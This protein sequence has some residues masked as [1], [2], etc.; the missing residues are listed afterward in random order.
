MTSEV[1]RTHLN[2]LTDIPTSIEKILAHLGRASRTVAPR[3]TRT[4]K[5]SCFS[6]AACTTPSPREG[7]LKLK[8]FPYVQAEG[9]P[10]GEL[11][12]GPNAL[13]DENLPVIV[14]ATRDPAG[15]RL[16]PALPQDFADSRIREKE[17]RQSHRHCH[18]RRPR[19]HPR[20]PDRTIYVPAAPEL[21]LPILEVVPLQLFA[22]HF[23]ILNGH[24]VGQPA[25]P[26]QVG[27]RMSEPLQA[28]SGA[29]QPAKLRRVPR[30]L[31]PDHHRHRD[32]PAH[33]AHGHLRR[34]QQRRARPRRHHTAHRHGR[35]AFH[36]N[37][38][39][40]NGACLSLCRL[41]LHLC[42]PGTETRAS[43]TSPAG[44]S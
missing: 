39:R 37:Q 1:T 43:A 23:A 8:E 42:R 11:R 24:D 17:R 38:L 3:P 7:A 28:Q 10:A 15:S 5:P 32:H 22:Y 20:S 34:D 14:L 30:P 18:R 6:D 27:Q 2:H 44:P 25:Q 4:R 41:R 16:R 33:R 9:L 36:R 21:L 19:N 35:H 13:V 12:H 29:G 31:G 40:Q 26:R